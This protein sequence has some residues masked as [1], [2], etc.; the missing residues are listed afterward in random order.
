MSAHRFISYGS[1]CTVGDVTPFWS[2]VAR[3]VLCF[4]FELGFVSS[5]M[6]EEFQ[7]EEDVFP[8]HMPDPA[9]STTTPLPVQRSI[10][11]LSTIPLE[12]YIALGG[13]HLGRG[14]RA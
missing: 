5:Q 10:H 14:V 11:T 8:A 3:D 13:H 9:T 4:F 7:E 12:E 1:S 2:L 6:F